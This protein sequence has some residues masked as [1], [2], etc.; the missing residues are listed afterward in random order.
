MNEIHIAVEVTFV[1]DQPSTDEQ[2]EAFL[3][4][5][6]EQLDSIGRDV[7]LGASLA[8]RTA[9]FAISVAGTDFPSAAQAFLGDIRTALHATGCITANWPPFQANDYVVRELADA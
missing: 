7:N 9:D 2:F 5:V 3:D 6:I 8:L 1:A 4:Q